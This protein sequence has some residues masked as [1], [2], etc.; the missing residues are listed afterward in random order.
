MQEGFYDDY[1]SGGLHPGEVWDARRF[2]KVMGVL[3]GRRRVLDYGCGMG[4]NYQRPLAAAVGEY[5]AA[6]VSQT[7]LA[8][9]AAKGFPTLKIAADSTVDAPGSSFDGVTCV[10]VFEHL[11][12]P[13][14]AARELFRVL[15]PGGVLVAT[16]PNFGYHAWRLMA[17]LRARV[18]SEPENPRVNRFNGVH[19]RYFSTVTLRRLL[20]DAGF[21]EVTIGSFDDATVWDVFRAFG[22]VARVSDFARN[23]L[24]APFHLRFL[25][26]ILP[27][28]FA[29]RIRAVAVK[30][31]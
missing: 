27:S 13:L 15:E 7:A 1:W 21:R 5:V 20:L 28:V 8:A 25:Q 17:F 16:V 18:P 23:R 3:A 19:I 9:T 30:A 31:P 10:E 2:E 24:P 12:D 11:F 26:D 22:P 6:D 29:Y 4:Y 14:A